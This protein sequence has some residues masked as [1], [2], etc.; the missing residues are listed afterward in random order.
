MIWSTRRQSTRS[1]GT[2]KRRTG[3]SSVILAPC[4]RSRIRFGWHCSTS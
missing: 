4:E 3:R 1:Q 2:R